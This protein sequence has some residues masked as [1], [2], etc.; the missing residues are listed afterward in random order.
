M[1][2]HFEELWEKC[3]QFHQENSA[4]DS[5]SSIIEELS[6]KIN[7]YKALDSKIDSLPA[8]ESQKIKSRTLGEIV[9]TLT[10]LSLRENINVYDSLRE[11]LQHRMVQVYSQKH[12]S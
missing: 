10:N 9:L 3:E 2:I 1:A 7:L 6:I 4:Q 8:E 11:S 12:Q 5:I